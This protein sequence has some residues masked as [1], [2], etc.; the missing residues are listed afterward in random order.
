MVLQNINYNLQDMAPPIRRSYIDVT[1]PN[2][3]YEVV[4][5]GFYQESTDIRRSGE[6]KISGSSTFGLDFTV[7]GSIPMIEAETGETTASW[8]TSVTGQHPR[9]WVETFDRTVRVPLICPPLSKTR[10]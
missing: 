7:S 2:P 1:I 9:S 8:S 3:S 5:N 4:D 6:W 10:I